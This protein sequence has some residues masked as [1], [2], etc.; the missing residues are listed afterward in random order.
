M[1]FALLVLAVRLE[2]AGV[3][4]G[5]QYALLAVSRVF[6]GHSPK[7]YPA[8]LQPAIIRPKCKR[9]PA[10]S[11]GLCAHVVIFQLIHAVVHR[12]VHVHREYG[13]D[14]ASLPAHF[15]VEQSIQ[16]AVRQEQAIL[17]TE[18][19]FD[20]TLPSSSSCV[21]HFGARAK[22]AIEVAKAR[23]SHEGHVRWEFVVNE[24]R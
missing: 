10:F 13:I 2:D 1:I 3:A 22:G 20:V 21:R 23:V 14:D 11:G 6:V 19:R 5:E 4:T 9:L 24:R 12:T 7:E 15:Y 8:V 17:V 16:Q 18:W